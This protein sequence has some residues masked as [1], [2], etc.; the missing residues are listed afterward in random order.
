MNTLFTCSQKG[1]MLF[2]NWNQKYES[3]VA[4]YSD[5][6]LILKDHSIISISRL[7]RYVLKTQCQKLYSNNCIEN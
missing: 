7:E 5:E 6:W 4:R 1:A 2:L 3:L